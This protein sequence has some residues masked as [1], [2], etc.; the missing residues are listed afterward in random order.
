[1][2]GNRAD[3]TATT[4][5]ARFSRVNGAAN[6]AQGHDGEAGLEGGG[7]QSSGL[8]TWMNGSY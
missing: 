4:C 3:S 7:T 1:M 5:G 2:L 6:R 8:P